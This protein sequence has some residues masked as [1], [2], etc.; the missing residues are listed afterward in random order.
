MDAE[1]E[2]RIYLHSGK[3]AIMGE[4]MALASEFPAER[5]CI[6]EA[7]PSLRCTTD[8]RKHHG[9][10]QMMLLNESHPIAAARRLRFLVQ[11]YRS[12]LSIVRDSPP[13]PVRTRSAAMA[14]KFVEADV[15]RCWKAAAHGEQFAHT[16]LQSPG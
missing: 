15:D 8:V 10:A 7:Y 11:L 5:L 9:A 3:V 12:I 13:I 14:G 6:L 1:L 4:H 2:M 16:V